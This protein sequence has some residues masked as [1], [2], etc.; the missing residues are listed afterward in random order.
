MN[1]K[2]DEINPPEKDMN[3][4]KIGSK[5][6]DESNFSSKND[7]SLQQTTIFTV[8]RKITLK[9]LVLSLRFFLLLFILSIQLS[10]SVGFD[11]F[12]DLVY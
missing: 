8:R 3:I 6:N 7:T 2:E 10:L 9:A 5:N 1:A 11:M 12:D 4:F